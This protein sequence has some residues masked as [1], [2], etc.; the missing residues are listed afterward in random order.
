MGVVRIR[1]EGKPT[2]PT[3][4]ATPP[5]NGSADA[6]RLMLTLAA[7]IAFGHAQAVC[8]LFLRRVCGWIPAPDDMAT[9]AL[10][11]A[12]GW[13]LAVDQTRLVAMALGL[14]CF[15]LLAGRDGWQRLG[16]V[17]LA[18]GT[19]RLTATVSLR[20]MAGW[21]TT[22]GGRELLTAYPTPVFVPVWMLVVIALG[23]I[24]LGLGALKLS[25]LGKG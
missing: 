20:L 4:T 25:R 22:F 2:K 10:D 12:P 17:L 24:G 1:P 21:P 13:V 23:L 7:G 11:A 9:L 8:D 3:R 15:G 6:G 14:I 18:L 19:W 5:S 16:A